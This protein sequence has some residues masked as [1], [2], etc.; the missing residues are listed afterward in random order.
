MEAAQGFARALIQDSDSLQQF[1]QPTELALSRRLGI[2]YS[3]VQH[4]FLIGYN[5]DPRV[6]TALR[7]GSL[8]Y[9]LRIEE[10]DGDF[11]RLRLIVPGHE[12]FER[13]FY[14]EGSQLVSPV[15]YFSRD[16][17]RRHSRYFVFCVSDTTRFNDASVQ[18]LERFMDSALERL[19]I[20]SQAGEKLEKEKLYYFLCKDEEEIERLTG[21]PSRGMGL[22]AYDYVLTTFNCHYHE[23]LHL[24]VNFKLGTTPLYTHPFLQEGIAVAMGGRGGK[25]P[26]VILD[27]GAFL[28]QSGYL[29]YRSLLDPRGFAGLDASMS[30]PLSGL[31]SAFLLDDL[32]VDSYLELYRKYSGTAEEVSGRAIEESDLPP[33]GR[34]SNF[35]NGYTQ[36]GNIRFCSFPAEPKPILE[37]VGASVHDAGDDYYF[38]LKG[39]L[40]IEGGPVNRS[41]RSPLF[42]ELVPGGAYSGE[43]YLVVANQEEIKVYDLLTG[44]LTA[45]FVSAFAVVPQEIPAGEDG[46]FEFCVRKEVFDEPMFR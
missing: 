3:G 36:Y 2:T 34:W 5:L 39:S 12:E 35:L 45:N 18:R 14:F 32:G 9:R 1:V 42:E 26:R 25:E 8:E 4:K 24:L 16:W 17:P 11:S 43:K 6:S 7:E 23:L 28:A 19:D 13:S 33:P 40:L 41:Y 10:L 46:L 38:R 21:F 20:S 31:Y 37:S 15:Y 44:N 30:Y 22:L 29:D 27:L